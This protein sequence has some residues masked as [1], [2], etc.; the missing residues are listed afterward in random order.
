LKSNDWST[1]QENEVGLSSTS[2]A[3][4]RKRALDPQREDSEL[5][6]KSNIS[7][8]NDKNKKFV[9]LAALPVP[10]FI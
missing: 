7:K 2:L 1:K 5:A 10:K 6:K 3:N 4:L 8:Q 9:N